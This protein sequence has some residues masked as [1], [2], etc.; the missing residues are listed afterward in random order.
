MKRGC[1]FSILGVVLLLLLAV[2]LLRG[3]LLEFGVKG[4]EVKVEQYLPPNYDRS[5]VKPLFR[6][7]RTALREKRVREK[8][9]REA[10]K[11]IREALKDKKITRDEMD[12]IRNKLRKAIKG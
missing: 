7:F 8:E 1:L 10:V 11:Y 5:G 2:I 12:Q 4:L 6:E 3:R 9:V